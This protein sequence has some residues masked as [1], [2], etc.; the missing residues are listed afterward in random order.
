MPL[1]SGAPDEAVQFIR[2]SVPEGVTHIAW[3][4]PKPRAETLTLS[5]ARLVAAC[6][7]NT[8]HCC[9]VSP[10]T[11]VGGVPMFIQIQS[12]YI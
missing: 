8:A 7:A 3:P 5:I 2:S 10:E 9:L 6:S 1:G 4:V 12:T 11:M